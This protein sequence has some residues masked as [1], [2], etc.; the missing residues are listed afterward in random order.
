MKYTP[1]YFDFAALEHKAQVAEMFLLVAV[2]YILI[3]SVS[4][5]YCRLQ[6]K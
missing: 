5:I 3:F 1:Q 6:S 4:W 2:V